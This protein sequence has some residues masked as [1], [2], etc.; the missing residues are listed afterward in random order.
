[1]RQQQNIMIGA[2]S[3]YKTLGAI[4]TSSDTM[5]LTAKSSGWIDWDITPSYDS[6]AFTKVLNEKNDIALYK[7]PIKGGR[8]TAGPHP[9]QLEWL[10][11]VPV[12]SRGKL[13]VLCE[14]VSKRSLRV[15]MDRAEQPNGVTG[16]VSMTM[17]ANPGGL[18]AY[19]DELAQIF[20]PATSFSSSFA[21]FSLATPEGDNCR[22]IVKEAASA[23]EQA[24]VVKQGEGLYSIELRAD[25]DDD[26]LFEQARIKL[27]KI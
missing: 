18:A 3:L 17:L 23:D 5:Y 10:M 21:E 22:M 15:R 12:K 13:P 8:L 24:F 7:E 20:G 11:T 27:V 1:V 2:V 25:Q 16:L 26:S 14:D 4:R 6:F 9:V 19:S